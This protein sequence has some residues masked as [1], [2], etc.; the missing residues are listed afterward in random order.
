MKYICEM[1][2]T[3][4]GKLLGTEIFYAVTKSSEIKEKGTHQIVTLLFD[5]LLH[6]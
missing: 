2:V 3:L 4:W 6:K 5:H 1:V